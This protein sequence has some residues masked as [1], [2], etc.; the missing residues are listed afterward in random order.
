MR[1][2]VSRPSFG[3]TGV[4]MWSADPRGVSYLRAMLAL[5]IS[6]CALAVPVQLPDGA[7]AG[8][9]AA[10]AEH[11]GVTLGP[12]RSGARAR[13]HDRGGTWQV[14]VVDRDGQLHAWTVVPPATAPEREDLL[15]TIASVAEPVDDLALDWSLAVP[16]ANSPARPERSARSEPPRP[17]PV[18]VQPV[19]P[20]TPDPT[21]EAESAVESSATQPPSPTVPD[22]T[23]DPGPTPASPARPEP[24][25]VID[26]D[27]AP[28]PGPAT[29][30]VARLGGG[31]HIRPGATVGVRPELA[32]GVEHGRLRATIG[33]AWSPRARLADLGADRRWADLTLLGELGRGGDGLR[34]TG[35]CGVS[36]RRWRDGAGVV[37]TTRH[38]VLGGALSAPIASP[39]GLL[40]VARAWLVSD[41]GLTQVTIDGEP[42]STLFPV[43]GGF[44]LDLELARKIR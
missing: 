25:V 33:L 35:L 9:W 27:E 29:A 7:E 18:D 39:G 17:P 15:A 42:A 26:L 14:V 38:A 24:L 36:S 4:S 21:P 8:A 16:T 23:P 40:T 43:A 10:S 37:A 20:P 34:A 30:I 13:V 28:D 2:P 44:S 32:A 11:A 5:L 41:A 1:R 3:A 6:L 22:R 12:S 19:P 31:P